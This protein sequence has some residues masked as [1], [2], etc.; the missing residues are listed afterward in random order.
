VVRASFSTN[1]IPGRH[2]ASGAIADG[3]GPMHASACAR[4]PH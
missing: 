2:R 1:V 3:R 4:S